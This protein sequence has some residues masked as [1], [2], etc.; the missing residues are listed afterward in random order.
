[1]RLMNNRLFSLSGFVLAILSA[2]FCYFLFI[3]F[4]DYLWFDSL[5]L[6][7][8]WW[9]SRGAQIG[10]FVLGF[11]VSGG[12]I[13]AQVWLANYFFKRSVSDVTGEFHTRFRVVNWFL[14]LLFNYVRDT[15][16]R[17]VS[18]TVDLV[19]LGVGITFSG[20]FGLILSMKWTTLLL[21]F[22]RVPYGQMDPVFFK[23]ISFYL[24]SLP[25]IEFLYGWVLALAVF[26]FLLVLFIYFS[27]KLFFILFGFRKDKG[28]L[29][30]HLGCFLIALC[31]LMAL[32]TWLDRLNMLFLHS[33]AIFGIGYTDHHVILPYKY[34]MT[35]LWVVE[36]AFI[37]YWIL[38][39]RFRFVVF[40]LVCLGMTALVGGQLLPRFVQGYTVAPNE[41]TKES[42]YILNAIRMT[43]EAYGLEEIESRLFPASNTLTKQQ[44][45]ANAT[46]L[47]N[48]RLWDEVPL[49]KT[50]SQLQE[51]RQYY[52]FKRVDV[53]R[54]MVNNE[55]RQVL[56][57]PR[58]LDVTQLADQAKTWINQHLVYT[59]GYG[60]CM[61]P[62]NEITKEGLPNF[63]IKDIPPV[64][65]H[66]FKVTRPEIYF[67]EATNQY[68]LVNTGQPE[69]D[70]PKGDKNVYTSYQGKGGVLLDSFWKRVAY[71]VHL[72]D[73]KLLISTLVTKES[74][75][76]SDRNFESR[77]R[78]IAPFLLFDKDAYL[79]IS[80]EGRLVWVLDAYTSSSYFPY[81]EPFSKT[82]NYLRHSVKVTM[83]AY[84][85]DM[86]FYRI[87]T[88]DPIIAGYKAM[89]PGLF[90]EV[91]DMPA[92]LLE[93]WRY[94]KDYFLIQSHMFCTYHMT[95]PQVFYNKEDLWAFP[96]GSQP[97]YM[98]RKLPD[99][100]PQ[101]VLAMAFTPSKKNNMIAFMSVVCD[102]QS[103]GKK[104]V[105]KFPKERTVYG[106]TQLESRIDQDTEI[107][108]SIT[109]WGQVG[110]SVIRGDLMVIPIEESMVYVEPIYL[111]SNQSQ[112]PE[113]KR[114]IFSCNDKIIMSET[115]A[116]AI[117]GCF[118]GSMTDTA[119]PPIETG[120]SVQTLRDI[121]A[122]YLK[123]R[124]H[125]TSEVQFIEQQLQRGGRK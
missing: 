65:E 86:T 125:I 22:H 111:Q 44:V 98:V 90:Q 72:S 116:G 92:F 16:G 45:E 31:G 61:S 124:D 113:L 4:P 119:V 20:L 118:E 87:D 79:V 84:D 107:S 23:D 106:P 49:Q 33:G 7:S 95:D 80:P 67:G 30:W 68:V 88:K 62:V 104:V 120:A 42:P 25:A 108:Q 48:I 78:R 57:A 74:R 47:R 40:G 28:F 32:G 102:N 10:F 12:F 14:R 11:L 114:V 75:I 9:L 13:A 36:G 105:F 17:S 34:C 85:G 64:V 38:K 37:L 109:L 21:A 5:D 82:M 70:Y 50:F 97:Y 1:M 52:E 101:F 59:H 54:Y 51:I 96:K 18:R 60:L 15:F 117:A 26:S 100:D 43:R 110:S 41:L 94:P 6:L 2:I 53:D 115:L 123:L 66:D 89:F 8:V 76:I 35:V 55:I 73:L 93:H 24:F 69:F 99:Q 27:K 39:D 71:A 83:D 63:Y 121:Q 3:I 56:L 81:S 91:S 103:Y 46:I 122:R 112:F 19:I 58:E 29:R 77:A